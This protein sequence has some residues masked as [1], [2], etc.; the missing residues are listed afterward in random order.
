[1]LR[2]YKSILF[3]VAAFAIGTPAL[4]ANM[5]AP[6]SNGP[7]QDPNFFPLSVWWQAP[8]SVSHRY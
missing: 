7:S 8:T 1:M 5:Y 6:W 3:G 4:A 2:H